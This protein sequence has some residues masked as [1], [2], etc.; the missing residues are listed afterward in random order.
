[1]TIEQQIQIVDSHTGGEPTRVIV[2]GGPDLGTGTIR[3]RRERFQCDFDDVRRAV[4]LEPRGSEVLVGALLCE[5]EDINATAGVIFFNNVGF[6]NMCGHGTIGLMV[7]L[8]RMGRIGPGEHLLETPVGNVRA[9]LL[10]EYRVEV[11][12]VPSWRYRKSVPVELEDFGTVHGDIVWG[13]NWFFLCND[14]GQPLRLENHVAL[15]DFGRTIR[16]ALERDGITGVDGGVIDHIELCGPS[17]TPNQSDG[18]NFVLCPGGV[19]DRSPCGTGT[20]AKMASLAADGVLS[21][22]EIWRQEGILGSVFEGRFSVMSEANVKEADGPVILPTVVG[23]A[24]VTAESTLI[25]Q[26]DDPCASGIVL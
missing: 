10:D 2:G 15:T 21:E 7:T 13:G 9:R 24:W 1:M 20:S 26:Q 14:H 3:E 18:K 11:C 8:A 16:A 5:P 6:L 25:I 23:S 4:I 17:S 22:G 12:N 19:F